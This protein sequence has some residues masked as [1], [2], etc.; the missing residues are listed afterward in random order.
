MKLF[1][2]IVTCEGFNI[3]WKAPWP[4]FL[5][6]GYYG[7]SVGYIYARTT[8][9]YWW[10]STSG[11]PNTG[12]LF[13]HALSTDITYVKSQDSNRRGYGIPLRCVAR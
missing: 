12:I 6:T 3:P 11:V 8:Y 1:S 7:R 5:R 9:A 13:S 4:Y 2:L 10:S